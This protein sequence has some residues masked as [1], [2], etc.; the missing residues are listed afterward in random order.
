M[1]GYA[2]KFEC[3][4]TMFFKIRDKQLLKKYNQTWKRVEKLLKILYDGEP[5]YAH[6]D[7]YIKGKIK[8]Y[9]GIMI[10]NFQSKKMPK[11]KVPYKC[12]SIMML[13]SVIKGKKKYYPQTLL[14]ECKYEPKKI[15]MENFIDDNLEKSSSDES[16]NDSIDETESGNEKDN[17][18]FN[19]LKAKKS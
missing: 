14:V 11:E 17:D 2:K 4:T 12:L 7:K 18:E 8:T 13:D 6:N 19:E 9:A 15:K 16:D 3:N 5:I 10:T 1:T